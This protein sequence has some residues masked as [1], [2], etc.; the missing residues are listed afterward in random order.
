MIYRWYIKRQRYREA[1]DSL[2]QLRQTEIQAARDLFYIHCLILV[3]QRVKAE[4]DH[5]R[6]LFTVRRNYRA[7][8]ASGLVM[9]LQQQCGINILIYV[10][11]SQ[12]SHKQRLTRHQYSAEVLL[13]AT[14]SNH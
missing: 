5:F 11:P 4:Q 14:N 1:F 8:L 13:N 12:P 7:M 2:C 6:E 3:E 10:R 9:L